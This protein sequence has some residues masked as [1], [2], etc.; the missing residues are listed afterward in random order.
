VSA[1]DVVIPTLNE[2][3]GLARTIAALRGLDSRVIV[4]DGGSTD[5]TL[6]V[7]RLAGAATVSSEPGRGRQLAAGAAVGTAPWLLFLHA[8]TLL[9]DTGL[10]C[11]RRFVSEPRNGERAGYF[12]LRLAS[13]ARQARRVERLAG[14]RCRSLGLPYGDQGLVLAR[15]FYQRLGGF[16]PMP[17]MEDVD[18]VRRIGRRRLVM[19]P[20]DALTSAR[21]YERDGW[22]KRPLL[23]LSCLALHFAGVPPGL[24]RDLYGR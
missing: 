12:R 4:C 7:A 3:A 17:L 10:D 19:L 21:R 14:W 18:L 6:A 13:P 23:N 24:L 11:L 9:D 20:A 5:Q 8:D 1:L 22:L 15:S 2:G 16:R